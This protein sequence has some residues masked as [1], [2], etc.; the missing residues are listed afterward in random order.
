MVFRWFRSPESGLDEVED[1]FAG[2]LSDGRHVFDLAMSARVA[3][4]DPASL[5][6]DLDTTE[7]R[8]DE[9]E[10]EIRRRLLVHASVHGAT[11]IAACLLYMSV[12][13]DAERVADLSKNLFRVA[14]IAGSPPGGALRDDL[15]RLRDDISPMIT[16]AAQIFADE[17][18]EAGEEFIGRARTIQTHCRDE[19]D[20]LLV[21]GPDVPQPAAAALTY[22]QLGRIVANLLNIVSS[23]VMPLDQL[24][25]PELDESSGEWG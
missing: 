2:M 11:D 6:E 7:E 12:A 20:R 4:A 17:D 9:A 3:G 1:L 18:R 22:R 5:A 14:Q 25:Y 23:V 19:M 15:M 24:D 13:K 10:R 8:T 16:E 21:A